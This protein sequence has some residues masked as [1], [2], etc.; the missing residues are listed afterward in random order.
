M[1]NW[2]LEE[3]LSSQIGPRFSS[4]F[5]TMNRD[6]V[7]GH[8]HNNVKVKVIQRTIKLLQDLNVPLSDLTKRRTL[9]VHADSDALLLL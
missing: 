7:N 4:G 1:W 9:R 5:T 2:T 8:T 3:L 6:C